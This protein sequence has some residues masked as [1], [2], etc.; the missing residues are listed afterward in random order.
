MDA[1]SMRRMR[2][3]IC[4][5]CTF[6]VT[7]VI[8]G[9]T[10]AAVA[11]AVESTRPK[12]ADMQT[13]TPE[14]QG[15]LA[16]H[17]AYRAKHG[18]PPLVWSDVIA[19]DA[20]EWISQCKYGHGGGPPR[21]K[22]PEGENLFAS[23]GA[24]PM[25]TYITMASN[26]WYHEIKDYNYKSPTLDGIGGASVGHFTQLIWKETTTIGCAAHHCGKGLKGFWDSTSSS[27]YVG[28]RYSPPGN[29]ASVP[30]LLTNVLPPRT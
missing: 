8:F 12:R 9:C 3:V 1:G 14:M 19:A 24:P 2:T 6:L 26:N 17:N 16:Q 29:I 5:G 20:G 4:C 23:G 28:C 10:A 21:S 15:L 11:S 13:L 25:G 22:T 27:I 18:S 7:A 30:Q